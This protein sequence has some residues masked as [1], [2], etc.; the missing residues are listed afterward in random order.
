MF[1]KLHIIV[2]ELGIAGIGFWTYLFRYRY[3]LTLNSCHSV[4][5]KL[6]IRNFN[7]IHLMFK[8]EPIGY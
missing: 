4:I 1:N 8:L 2:S 7:L 6:L 5:D 3:L